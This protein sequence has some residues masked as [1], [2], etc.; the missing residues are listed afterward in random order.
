VRNHIADVKLR[1]GR[2]TLSIYEETDTGDGYRR[3]GYQGEGCG[4][5]NVSASR[6]HEVVQTEMEHYASAKIVGKLPEP[7]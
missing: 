3:Y 6:I 1:N 7:V 2:I 4:G 5:C